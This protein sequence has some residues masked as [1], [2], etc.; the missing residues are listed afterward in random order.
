VK[1]EQKPVMT[2]NDARTQQLPNHQRQVLQ[3]KAIA[4]FENK[5]NI[6]VPFVSSVLN[7]TVG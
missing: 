6:A 4:T 3:P 5:V 7:I 2:V 1:T